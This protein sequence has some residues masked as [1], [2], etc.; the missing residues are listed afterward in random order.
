MTTPTPFDNEQYNPFAAPE[1]LDHAKDTMGTDAERIRSELIGHE[2][3]IQSIGLLYIVGSIF[4]VL[5]GTVTSLASSQAIAAGRR[6]AEVAVLIGVVAFFLGIAQGIVGFGL[7]RLRSWTRIPV[8]V[9][10]SLGLIAVPLGTIINGYILYLIFSEKGNRV[11]S[12]EYQE[13]IQQTPHIKYQTSIIVK[14]L[15]GLLLAV[16]GLGLMA[17]LL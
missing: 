5:F 15:L 3:S 6:D 14:I 4:A 16:I 11:F 13:V 7:R 12:P 1:S 2:T 10:S 9:I 17:I 8:G